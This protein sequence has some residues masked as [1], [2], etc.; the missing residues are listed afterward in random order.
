M[1]AQNAA[2]STRLH[3]LAVRRE[4]DAGR[5]PDERAANRR[6][7][8]QH[9]HDQRPEEGVRNADDA[10]CEAGQSALND[11]DDDRAL[12]R[13]ARDRHEPIRHLFAGRRR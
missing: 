5:Y 12:H 11:P 8:R 1:S 3:D 4:D 9:D 2:S 6:Q 7:D 10:E 13:R